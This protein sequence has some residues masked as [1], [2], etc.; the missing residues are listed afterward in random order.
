MRK[1][2]EWLYKRYPPKLVITVQDYTM[3]REEI[4]QLNVAAQAIGQL[5][6]RIVFLEQQIKKLNDANGFVNIPKGSI[7][8]ER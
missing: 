1:L 2:I 3:L 7:R 4:G 5:H 8:L 6:D